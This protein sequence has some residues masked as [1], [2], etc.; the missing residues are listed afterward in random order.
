MLLA[1]D[2][3]TR[4]AGVALMDSEG[5][6]RQ[7]L[8]WRSQQNHTVEL[9]PSVDLALARQGITLKD[10]TGIAVAL[11]PGSFSALRVGLSIAKGLAWT[12]GLPLAA[13]T[14]L[15]IEAFPYHAA[16]AHL[17]ALVDAGRG[18]A[19][20]ALYQPALEGLHLMQPEAIA[21]PGELAAL[22][23][24]DTLV[25]G[26]GLERFHEE[27]RALLGPGARLAFPYQTGLRLTALAHLGHTRLQAGQTHDPATLQ[28]F[29]L[30]RP[31][32]TEPTPPQ[33]ASGDV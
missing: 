23:P 27:L 7:L 26:E 19:A 21:G 29:Y 15:E 10:L 16:G 25:C 12:A 5:R 28:P 11:G 4:Y 2:T 14:T 20:Y 32:I 22:L 33:R 24:K 13:A 18:E 3:S 31:S 30:R 1:I 8:Y 17:C 9:L 6:L